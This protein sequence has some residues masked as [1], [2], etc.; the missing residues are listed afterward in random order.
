[1]LNGVSTN[2]S[3]AMRFQIG[4][5]SGIETTGYNSSG[6][7][8]GVS[9]TSSGSTSGFDSF[10]DGGSTLFRYGAFTLVLLGSNTWMLTGAFSQAAA[11]IFP[12]AGSKTLGGTLD[13]VRIT[14]VNGTDTFDAGSINILFE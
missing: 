8:I 13:R 10:G 5:S 7:W 2:G 9:S 3:S 6:G 11:Y 14:T 4:T 12:I 1:M